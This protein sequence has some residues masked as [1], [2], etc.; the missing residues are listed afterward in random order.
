MQR[1]WY[2]RFPHVI[3]R[4]LHRLLRRPVLSRYIRHPIADI[5]FP[6]SYML[7]EF[8]SPSIGQMLSQTW[9][10]HRNDLCRRS[11]LFQSI[12]RIILSLARVPQLS[13]GSYRFNESGVITLTN[14]PLTS[15]IVALENEGAKRIIQSNQVYHSTEDFVTDTLKLHDNAFIQNPNGACDDK[16]C[17][18]LMAATTMLRTISHDYIEQKHRNGPYFLQFTDLTRSN[19]FVDDDWNIT[20]LLD[21]EWI[22]ALPRE[23]ISVPHWLSGCDLI[24]GFTGEELAKFSAVRLEFMHQF[25][26]E[27]DKMEME[28]DISLT[29]TMND[30]WNSKRVWFWYT[31][32]TGS[33]TL[34]PI[35]KTYI[36][37]K[38]PEA[39]IAKNEKCF[40]A[41]WRPDARDIMRKKRKDY[42]GYI[43]DFTKLVEEHGEV[44]S[45]RS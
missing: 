15:S 40:S 45:L 7:I 10:K 18:S 3:R 44:P 30:I 23:M 34:Y 5:D 32:N 28:H 14:R 43:C 25:E 12:S 33:T 42:N 20:C 19:V 38:F 35:V 11:K 13:I 26:L 9:D 16:E 24:D 37:S 6:L 2:I 36:Y 27:E 8:I 22:S 31:M 29:A 4:H 41:L 17:R 21:L 39:D 1:P